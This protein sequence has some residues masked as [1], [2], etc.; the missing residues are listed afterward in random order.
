MQQLLNYQQTHS[1]VKFESCIESVFKTLN[2]KQ[3]ATENLV[4]FQYTS[5]A[6]QYSCRNGRYFH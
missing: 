5:Q 3:A 6:E 4:H 1:N 2:F